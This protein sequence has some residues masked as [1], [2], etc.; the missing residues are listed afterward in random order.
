MLK[1]NQVEGTVLVS[2]SISVNKMNSYWL[3]RM[4]KCTDHMQ[5]C[6]LFLEYYMCSIFN[7]DISFTSTIIRKVKSVTTSHQPTHTQSEKTI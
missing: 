2:V 6:Q 4:M 5:S 7:G 1:V 3:K